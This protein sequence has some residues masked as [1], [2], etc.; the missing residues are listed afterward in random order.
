MMHRT[1]V[2]L[3]DEAF[4]FL[5]AQASQGRSA[6]LNQLLLDE[7]KRSL[8]QM[9]LRANQEEASDLACRKELGEWDATLS[10]GLDA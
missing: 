10:D 8:H 2:S 4:N 3:N 7:Q 5:N 1:T 9:L 6:Y